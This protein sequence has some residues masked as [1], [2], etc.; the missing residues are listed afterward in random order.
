MSIQALLFSFQG[1]IGRKTYWLWNAFYYLAIIGLTISMSKLFPG[2]VQI[3]LPVCLLL[4]MLPDLAI[5][6]K[7][8]HD[9]GKSAYWLL[10][11]IPLVVGRLAS[12]MGSNSFLEPEA[13][14]ILSTSLAL[15]CGV[16]ILVECGFMKG[17]SGDNQ[18]GPE[19]K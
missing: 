3:L 7:R 9:R 4:L 13:S 18:Y 17:I 8:W 15:I 10:L 14:T 11:N 2:Y 5:T 16:W 1:R 19:P 12:P 6:T